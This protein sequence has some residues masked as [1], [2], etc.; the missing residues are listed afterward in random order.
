MTTSARRHGK[1]VLRRR[2][3][4][5]DGKCGFLRALRLV[6]MTGKG[7]RLR[8]SAVGIATPV[9]GLV[10]NDSKIG[11]RNDGWRSDGCG[12]RRWGLPHQSADWF[13][14]TTGSGLPCAY[15]ARNDSNKTGDGSMSTHRTVPCATL[16]H[17]AKDKKSCKKEK[18]I[19]S[20]LAQPFIPNFRHYIMVT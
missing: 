16:C 2:I 10:R 19:F 4:F 8:R 11:N 14:M 13:A 12:A 6:E 3:P 9:C 15:G 1:P 20:K 18:I 17:T 5:N 7:E